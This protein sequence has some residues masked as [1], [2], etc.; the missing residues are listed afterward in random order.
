MLKRFA[1][2]HDEPA[3]LSSSKPDSIPDITEGVRPGR[4]IEDAERAPMEHLLFGHN[5]GRE[6]DEYFDNWD[7]PLPK[8]LRRGH[9][10]KHRKPHPP[11]SAQGD[12]ATDAGSEYVIDPITNRKVPKPSSPATI[13]AIPQEAM[14]SPSRPYQSQFSSL[15]P[16]DVESTTTSALKSP[17]VGP[18]SG[19][20]ATEKT[21]VLG[22]QDYVAELSE[23]S[24]SVILD[25]LSKKQQSVLWTEPLTSQSA[26]D[27]S[28]AAASQDSIQGSSA[29][30]A[31]DLDG[32]YEDLHKYGAVTY[33]EPDGKTV[34][35][36]ESP[37]YDDLTSY[38]AFTSCEPDGKD[39]TDAVPSED[40]EELKRYKP[41]RSCEPDGKYAATSEEA[42]D[43]QELARYNHPFLSHE[44]DGL[45]ATSYGIPGPSDAEL[46]DYVPFRSHEPDGKYA[47][48][49][50]APAANPSELEKYESAPLDKPNKETE[51]ME[52]IQEELEKYQ[53]FRSHEPDGSY[54]AAAQPDPEEED[55]GYHEAFG[56]E[57]S[58]V[59]RAAAET[60]DII[61]PAELRRYYAVRFNEPDGKKIEDDQS[62]DDVFDYDLRDARAEATVPKT[63][64]RKMLDSF[65]SQSA[66]VSDA[67]DADTS[68]SLHFSKGKEDALQPEP[69]AP[70]TGNYVRDFPEEFTKSW[71]SEVD[72][73]S[74]SAAE[75][76]TAGVLEPALNRHGSLGS[77]PSAEPPVSAGST[78]T[79]YKVLVYNPTMQLVDVA[80]TSSVVPDSNMPLTPADVLLRIS[81]PSKFL[82]YFGP[83][84]AQ[85]FEIVSGAGDVLIF[86]KVRE[87]ELP[88]AKAN[89]V[90]HV[91][92]VTTALPSSSRPAVN[93]IDMTGG[94]RDY[95]VATERFASPTG[96][97]N[98]DLPPPRFQSGI[99]VQREEPVFSGTKEEPKKNKKN[100]PKRVAI[101][102]L[103]V[104]GATYSLGVVSEYFKTGGSEGKRPKGL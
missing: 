76:T 83:L 12:H 18:V 90:G 67:I 28:Q 13:F 34:E 7:Q 66:A 40:L 30:I 55:S 5:N 63:H 57:D 72:V 92:A 87:A 98:Y 79:L 82:P 54:K 77:S 70:L 65:M 43:P 102:A 100:L 89:P 24:A 88:D 50:T 68:S 42:V 32:K 11:A 91:S 1:Y 74:S 104:A 44:P 62:K 56:Y 45:Y 31:Q 9:R 46:A 22:G 36:E 84:Q 73:S 21:P 37:A 51:A 101:G 52:D 26:A 38:R 81:N 94:S 53:P 58:E 39:Q 60:Q 3:K 10:R 8:H 85:G 35:Q 33:R 14:E 15:N 47:V 29:D 4:N 97:V 49:H 99:N 25:T 61:D 48:N 23:D 80:E 93:P 2:C 96:F 27:V 41:F 78:S 71:T 64:Y 6:Q 59:A 17:G 86:R 69:S 95:T 103:W 75:E 16:P 19:V 20:A